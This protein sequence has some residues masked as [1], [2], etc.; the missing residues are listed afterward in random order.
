MIPDRLFKGSPQIRFLMICI[1]AIIYGISLGLFLAPNHLAPGGVGGL[2]I[3][4]DAFIPIGVGTLTMLIN[5]PLLIIAIKKWGWRFLFTTFFAIIA[6]SLTA[7][8]CTYFPAFTQNS[9]LASIAGGALMGIGCGTVFRAGS[10]CGGT[11]IVTKLIKLKKPHLRISAIIIIIDSIIAILSGIVFKNSD[12]MLY[13]FIA[14]AVFSNFFDIVLY[15]SDSARMVFV[16]SE[17]SSEILDRLLKKVGVG[18]T[19]LKG[20]AGY[21]Q[22]DKDILL[23]AMKKQRLPSVQKAVLE[24][25]NQAFMLITSAGEVFGKGF[26]TNNSDF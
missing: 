6:F 1:G 21:S 9:L 13:S 18:C 3:I 25:D 17:K 15:G 14:L 7:D 16:I 19:V 12:N 26:K 24:I 4:I 2:S 8:V 11:E 5:L 23:C 20:V 22:K 10:S